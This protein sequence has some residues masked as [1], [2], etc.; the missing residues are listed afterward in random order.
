MQ[1]V[2]A[3]FNLILILCMYILMTLTVKIKI[4]LQCDMMQYGR[5]QKIFHYN[6]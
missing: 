3:I 4:V 1:W 5:S 6:S 2:I